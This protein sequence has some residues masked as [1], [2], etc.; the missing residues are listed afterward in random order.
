MFCENC[1]KQIDDDAKFCEYCGVAIGEEMETVEKT[2]ATV[3]VTKKSK[4]K[5]IIIAIVSAIILFIAV[6]VAYSA[7]KW[8]KEKQMSKEIDSHSIF[9][10][11]DESKPED[12]T[13]PTEKITTQKVIT[14]PIATTKTTTTKAKS[15]DKTYSITFEAMNLSKKRVCSWAVM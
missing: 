2:T 13:K 15:N 8:F 3:F 7:Y 11:D 14:T 9:N 5:P 6:A 10:S 4:K 12:T 1:G